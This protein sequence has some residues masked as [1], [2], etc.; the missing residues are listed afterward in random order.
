MGKHR[1]QSADLR[2]AV[3]GTRGPGCEGGIERHVEELVPLL[4]RDVHSIELF[5]RTPYRNGDFSVPANVHVR[6]LWAPRLHWLETPA[7][8]LLAALV[9]IFQRPDIVHIHAIGPALVT[10]LVRLFGLRVV[11]TH[12]G[13]DYNR[14]RWGLIAR[15][16]LKAGEFLGMRFANERIVISRDIQRHIEETYGKTSWLIPNGVRLPSGCSSNETLDALG[17]VRGRYIAQVSR[18]VPEK[19]Q[20][21]LINAFEKAQLDDWKLAIVGTLKDGDEYSDRVRKRAAEVPGV[22]LAGFRTSHELDA[23]YAGAGVFVL[24]SSHEGLPI[25]LLEALSY[26][27]T[28]VASDIP[29]NREVDLP[30]EQYFPLGDIDALAERLQ[31]YA[32]RPATDEERAMRRRLVKERYDW[33]NIASKTINV[34]LRMAD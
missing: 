5:G 11:V 32:T 8:S 34:Y 10:P 2:I 26:G 30:A 9:A 33:V 20:L 21:D 23:L 4:G 14:E 1:K 17:L 3:L 12:H 27:L 22:V 13:Y 7:H 18:C 31:H 24:P 28:A 29:S 15:L 16:V 6:W 19:R 25:A